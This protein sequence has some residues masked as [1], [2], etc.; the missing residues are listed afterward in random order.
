MAKLVSFMLSSQLVNTTI[1]SATVQQL[2]NPL[3]VLR[4]KFIPSEYSFAI[5]VGINDIDT[6]GENAIRILMTTPSGKDVVDTKDVPLPSDPVDVTL[7]DNLHGFVLTLPVQNAVIDE[8]GCFS[9][10]IFINGESIS[11][12]SI[13]VYRQGD[14]K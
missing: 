14:S 1:G 3:I 5:T 10:T 2:I 6:K 12:Q 9:L 13:P 11:T 4:P 7:P 8:E